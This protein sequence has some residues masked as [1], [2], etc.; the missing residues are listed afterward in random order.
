MQ[1][2]WCR[3][4]SRIGE[5]WAAILQCKLK[6]GHGLPTISRRAHVR[7]GAVCAC[8]QR[9][10]HAPCVYIF[11]VDL[12]ARCCGQIHGICIGQTRPNSQGSCETLESKDRALIVNLVGY[13]RRPCTRNPIE[14]R[15]KR[16]CGRDARHANFMACVVNET[17]MTRTRKAHNVC[18]KRRFMNH[19]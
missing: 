16:G 11:D 4:P 18:L 10:E 5:A 7:Y 12:Q 13:N 17:C 6:C 8:W 14:G 3:C 2:W 1:P 15:C 19:R 9:G